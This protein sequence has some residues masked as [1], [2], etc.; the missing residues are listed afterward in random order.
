MFTVKILDPFFRQKLIEQNFSFEVIDDFY[1]FKFDSQEE[2]FDFTIAQ[3]LRFSLDYSFSSLVKEDLLTYK[4]QQKIYSKLEQIMLESIMG[5]MYRSLRSYFSKQTLTP[6]YFDFISF[7]LSGIIGERKKIQ[8]LLYTTMYSVYTPS[9]DT[10]YFEFGPSQV[11]LLFFVVEKNGSVLLYNQN[12]EL[13]YEF[14]YSEQ[15]EAVAKTCHL[16]PDSLLV[17]DE[18]DFLNPELVIC[19]KKLLKK[20]VTFLDSEFPVFAN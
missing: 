7:F 12:S 5:E 9:S 1:Y 14:S 6:E 15:E 18:F 2:F 13:L 17:Y 8:N 20:K 4:D 19:I 16:N 3:T 11:G 10:N